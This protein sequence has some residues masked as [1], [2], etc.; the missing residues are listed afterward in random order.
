MRDGKLMPGEM[1]WLK[2]EVSYEWGSFGN[3]VNQNFDLKVLE[4]IKQETGRG[5]LFARGVDRGAQGRRGFVE[6]GVA[7]ITILS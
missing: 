5:R 7:H 1:Q 2:G 3:R 4:D 6:D